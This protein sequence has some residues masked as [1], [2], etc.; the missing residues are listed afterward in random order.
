MLIKQLFRNKIVIMQ[1]WDQ[2]SHRPELRHALEVRVAG[3]VAVVYFQTTKEYFIRQP[4]IMETLE[5]LP[6]QTRNVIQGHLRLVFPD[7]AIK[8]GYQQEGV[9]WLELTQKID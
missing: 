4:F 5:V 6:G 7:V 8:R 2:Q 9:A 1:E 3:E